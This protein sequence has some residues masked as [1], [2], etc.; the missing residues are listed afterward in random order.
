MSKNPEWY[1]DTDGNLY[2]TS[3]ENRIINPGEE[4]ELSLV[5]T[6][7]M[8]DENTGLVNNTA[9]IYEASNDQGI[10]DTDSTPGNK[11]AEEDD[12]G[13]A[14]VI[15]T[16]KTGGVVV[17]TGIVLGVLAIFAIGAYIIKKKVLTRI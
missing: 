13:T 2:N 4:V 7:T 17:Y 14:D 12:F 16:V 8:T 15:I 9:E 3:L 10:Q 11:G 1:Q 5:L 6:K